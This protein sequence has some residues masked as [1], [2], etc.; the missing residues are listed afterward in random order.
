M[1]P[2]SVNKI[3]RAILVVLSAAVLFSCS[4]GER[5]PAKSAELEK[6]M[7]FCYENGMFNGTVLVAEKGEVIYKDAWGYADLESGRELINASPFY[8]A[9]VSKQFTCMGIMIL[10]EQGKLSYDDPLSKFFPEF[11]DYANEV[12]IEHMMTHTSGIPDHFA[13]GSYKPDLTN[14]DVLEL[15]IKVD[16]LNFEPGDRF[17][18]SN[19]A[20]V[21]L[22][23][24][25]EKVSALPY[26]LFMK[27][28]IFDPLGMHHTLVFDHSKPVIENRAIG[29]NGAGDKAD[30]NLLTTGAGGMYSTVEDMFLW[31]RALH[32]GKLVP[33]ATLKKAYTPY[34]FNDGTKS[35]YGYGWGIRKD[36]LTLTVSHS[37]GLAGFITYI[38]RELNTENTLVMLTNNG[39]GGTYLQSI[40]PSI[41]SILQEKSFTMPKIPISFEMR[42]IIDEQG[43]EEAVSHYSS[44][45]E[46]NTEEYDF[47][48]AQLNMLGYQYL[49]KDEFHIALAIF[50]LNMEAYPDGFN[51]YD[52]YAEALMM[53]GDTAQAIKYYEKSLELNPDNDNAVSMILRLRKKR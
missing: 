18:Y 46:N 39:G 4:D 23:M 17:S 38:Q 21:L 22:S 5:L 37:G 3:T 24:I 19:G 44:L 20:Y 12:S 27:E 26:H 31:D 30:Y 48:E 35:D 25:A 33:A 43:I 49:E 15:L 42:R 40:L 50:K 6:L 41:D 53:K 8:L 28:Y 14:Q 52:S 32:E 45:K 47:S 36:E 13:L 9:S 2:L 1:K 7:K 29:F 34:T 10:H 16:T 11:P 51:T